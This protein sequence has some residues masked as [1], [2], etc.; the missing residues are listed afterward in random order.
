MEF[1]KATAED[2]DLLVRYRKQMYLDNYDR[3]IDFEEEMEDFF[4]EKM[5]DGSLT[6]WFVEEDG[7]IIATGGVMFYRVPP[8]FGNHSGRKGHVVNMWTRTDCR[9]R[10]LATKLLD[11]CV[12]EARAKGVTQLDLGA[13]RLG[14]F[15][16]EK[17]GFR[18]VE[19]EMIMDVPEA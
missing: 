2:V 1:R 18:A 8:S 6:Q 12:E 11:L 4:R 5:A 15:V 13:S 3:V 9:R 16:Y 17:Y 14:R 7:Q 19:D 10:G